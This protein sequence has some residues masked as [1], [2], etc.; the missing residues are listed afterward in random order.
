MRISIDECKERTAK[1]RAKRDWFV[2]A[3]SSIS[4]DNNDDDLKVIGVL[5]IC[6]LIYIM[7]KMGLEM[8]QL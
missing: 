1:M 6:L 4:W 2:K 5:N 8:S 7:I 3:C